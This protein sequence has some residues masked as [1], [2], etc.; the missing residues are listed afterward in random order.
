[1][2]SVTVSNDPA[3]V[4]L[5]VGV[6]GLAALAG[7]VFALTARVPSMTESADDAPDDST[8]SAAR[9]TAGPDFP[10][11]SPTP[12]STGSATPERRWN[13]PRP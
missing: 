5:I 11:T 7:V 13:E 4:F 8:D 9:P 2:P 3:V 12:W 6:M 10:P 1:V